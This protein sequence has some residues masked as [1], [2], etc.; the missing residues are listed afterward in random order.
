[1]DQISPK[2]NNYYPLKEPNVIVKQ[3]YVKLPGLL[4]LTLLGG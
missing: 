1:M 2:K 3:W 4:Y